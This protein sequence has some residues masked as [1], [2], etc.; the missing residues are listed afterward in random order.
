MASLILSGLAGTGIVV[1]LNRAATSPPT[2]GVRLDL[3]LEFLGLV[4]LF[5]I[6]QA[7]LLSSV[8]EAVES[9]L[10]ATR[11]RIAGKFIQ[12]S[13]ADFEALPHDPLVREV[14]THCSSISRAMSPFVYSLQSGV[15]LLLILGY[16]FYISPL[17]G[18]IIMLMGAQVGYSF[19][20]RLNTLKTAMTQ[21]AHRNTELSFALSELSSGFKELRLDMG[22]RAALSED[23]EICSANAATANLDTTA[24]NSNL[25]VSSTSTSYLMGAAAIFL[26]PIF[27]SPSTSSVRAV[28]TV[29]LFLMGPLAGCAGALQQLAIIRFATEQLD[30]FEKHLSTLVQNSEPI[31]VSDFER[32]DVDGI[33]Y[34]HVSGEGAERFSVG[35][36]H[37]NLRPGTITFLTGGNGSGKTTVLRMITGLY[38]CNAGRIFL[39]GR[40]VEESEME[41]YRQ[42]FGAVFADVHVF[43]RPYGMC[44]EQLKVLDERLKCFRIR[45]KLPE[46]LVDGYDPEKLSTGERKRLALAIAVAERRPVLVFDE[47]AADQDPQFRTQFY[48]EILQQ[49]RSEGRSIFA[50]THDE[51][52]FDVADVR[53]HMEE[54]KMSLIV[55]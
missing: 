28:L 16:L 6:T 35:P 30:N 52:F 43:R 4:V 34:E 3:A 8:C 19:V 48:R 21:A 32:I 39:N 31:T 5:R 47:L 9:S 40:Q 14:A 1:I 51:R 7:A 24:I 37:L 20:S 44:E 10:D 42:L 54:G 23:V 50:I 25:I 15:L 41:S 26:L 27:G 17:A 55:Q 53:Y 33:S 11:T 12:L 18:L 46:Q 2:T 38:S 13:L 49:L 22:K 45:H 29:I 36:V